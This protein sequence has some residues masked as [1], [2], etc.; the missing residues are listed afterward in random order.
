MKLFFER[1]L[2]K[3]TDRSE[4]VVLLIDID[5]ERKRIKN[6]ANDIKAKK[7]KSPTDESNIK[8]LTRELNALNI[9]RGQCLTKIAEIKKQEKI[10]N[11]LSTKNN[12]Y[13]ETFLQIASSVLNKQTFNKIQAIALKQLDDNSLATKKPGQTES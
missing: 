8:F 3:L 7:Y 9:I 12:V 4:I 11:R 5:T 2:K 6:K 1:A 10:N 13:A